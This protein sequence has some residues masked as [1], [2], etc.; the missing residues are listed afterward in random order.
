M[1]VVGT[2]VSFAKY[3]S[4][5][6]AIS[7]PAQWRCISYN[8][9]RACMHA[10][11]RVCTRACVHAC[12]RTYVHACVRECMCARVFTNRCPTVAWLACSLQLCLQI[13]MYNAP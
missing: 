10:C 8:V 5:R 12:M 4:P 1:Q 3:M 11:V 6:P 13:H 2:I 7:H 9:V